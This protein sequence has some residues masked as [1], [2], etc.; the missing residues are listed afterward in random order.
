YD[1][2]FPADSPAPNCGSAAQCAN[3]CAGGFKGFVLS[4]SGDARVNTD[5]AYWELGTAYPQ[6]SN[7][8]L[9][10]GYYHAMADYGPA[11]G[12]QFGHAQRSLATKDINGNNVGEACTYYL[13][14]IRFF[15]KL[16]FNSNVTGAVSWCKAPN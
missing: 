6:T 14:G 2:S 9:R 10:T 7:P 1:V 3:A 15:T 5:P 8:F 4:T 16:I 11:P 12:D 13:N